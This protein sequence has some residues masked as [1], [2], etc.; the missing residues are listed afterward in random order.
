[1]VVGDTTGNWHRTA[2][3]LF[4]PDWLRTGRDVQSKTQKTSLEPLFGKENLTIAKMLEVWPPKAYFQRN[5][6]AFN[7]SLRVERKRMP[8]LQLDN[9]TT[10]YHTARGWVRAA[11]NVNLD[12]VKGK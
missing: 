6:K 9:L 3:S 7:W 2:I 4:H 10:N 11:E 8:I 1:M 5:K 12:L